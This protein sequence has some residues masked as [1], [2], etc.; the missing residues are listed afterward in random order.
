MIAESNLRAKM[1]EVVGRFLQALLAEPTLIEVEDA[2]HMDEASAE[3][4]TYLARR[5][6]GV[7]W[8]IAIS[9]PAGRVRVPTSGG[10]GSTPSGWSR[11][12]PR[13]PPW[14]S[15]GRRPRMR[16]CCRMT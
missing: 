3:L 14:P 9:T 1:H 7:P 8:L 15:H 12:A 11:P 2:H 16:R 10:T 4:F 13:K 6:Q 5:V